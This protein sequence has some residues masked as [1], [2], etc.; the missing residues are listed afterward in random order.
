MLLGL[1]VVCLDTR[2]TRT[3]IWDDKITA[4]T[5]YFF[6]LKEL[7]QPNVPQNHFL[8]QQVQGVK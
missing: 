2:E 8:F 3:F 6:S 4:Y 5:S 1:V 7:T